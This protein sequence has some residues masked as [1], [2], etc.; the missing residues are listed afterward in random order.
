MAY[1]GKWRNSPGSIEP[2]EISMNGISVHK[3]FMHIMVPDN[4]Y[5]KYEE[6]ESM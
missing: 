2:L 1:T 5:L 4:L 3:R 6:G